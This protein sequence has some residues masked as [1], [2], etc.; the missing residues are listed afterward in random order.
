MTADPQAI[1]GA[2]GGEVSGGQ[3]LA[4]GPGHSATDRSL[5]IKLDSAAPE[6][7]VVH[8]FAD[9]D[10]LECRD[11]VRAKLGLPPKLRPKKRGDWLPTIAAYIYRDKNGAPYLR[12]QRTATKQ[13]FQQRW[14]GA[15][16]IKGKPQGPK[17]PYRLPELLAAAPTTAIYVCEGEKDC[18]SLAKIGF[19]ATTNS[20]GAD[21]G[22]GAKWT[23]DLNVHFKDRIVF[24]LPDNDEPGRKHAEHVARG[25]HSVA[26]SVR[27]VELPGL[28]PGGDVTDWLE[29]DPSGAR[30]VKACER[31]PLWEPGAEDVRISE[32]AGLSKFAYARRR[33]EEAKK[34]SITAAALDDVVKDARIAA[35]G[36]KLLYEHWNVEPWP[37]A[38][39]TADLLQSIQD[40]IKRHVIVSDAGALA[41]ALWTAMS[42]V[43][44]RSA[45]HSPILMVTSVERDSG[46]TTLLGV[47]GFLIR[48]SLLSVSVSAAALYRS[49]EK[50]QP[51]FVIDEADAIFRDNELLREVIN[52]SWTRGQ[53]VL[54]CQPETNEPFLFPTFCPKVI[55]L[56]GRKLP[57]TT[58]NR[59][60]I[61]ELKRKLPTE[62]VTDFL[63]I[64]DAGLT[65]LRRKLARWADDNADRLA[66]ANPVA[67]EGFINRVAAN[68]RLLLAIAELAGGDWPERARKAAMVLVGPETSLG[69]KLLSDVRDAFIAEDAEELSTQELVDYLT[70]LE[71][72]DWSELNRGKPITKVW[73]SRQLGKFG[74]ASGNV[75]ERGSRLRGWRFDT[76]TEAFARYL[77]V[78]PLQTRTLAHNRMKWAL[79]AKTNSHTP[80]PVCELKSRR[81]PIT[82]GLWASVRVCKGGL[83]K[84]H[85]STRALT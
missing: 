79:L 1:A 47:L 32:L 61:V 58:L 75:G 41:V 24:I 23:P 9:D 48:R 31:A 77:S 11:Y 62:K 45:V 43:H 12:V 5:S 50:W 34:L 15:D 56:K 37:E 10:P 39:D 21:N 16:W 63:H 29:T 60:I 69:I 74:L 85:R 49:I 3:V 83:P 17:V 18:D 67:P 27:V 76:F 38:V 53:G 80:K 46:K 20:E 2:L 64:D 14:D 84:G 66:A 51:S 6:G 57:D 54:R 42:W 65:E 8:C 22:K 72:R 26:K 71:D 44:E 7:F 55:G 35:S 28:P 4:P 13:F 81:N 73:L 70:G 52:A 68:W 59:S 33:K 78:T 30:L 25:L 19:T 36:G 82:T 40:R